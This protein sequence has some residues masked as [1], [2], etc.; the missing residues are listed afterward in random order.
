[1]NKVIS[2]EEISSFCMELSLL[3]HA[4]VGV[5]DALT[6]LLEDSDA[7]YKDLLSDMWRWESSQDG[8]KRRFW[9]FPGTMNTVPG[10]TDVCAAPFC[11][12]Q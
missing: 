1:M 2:H 12:R 9:H 6:L 10:W 3:L 7:S 11:I 4:G 8:W 5:G